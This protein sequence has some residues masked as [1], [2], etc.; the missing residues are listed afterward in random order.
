MVVSWITKKMARLFR[1]NQA[2]PILGEKIADLRTKIVASTKSNERRQQLAG[3][4]AE[5]FDQ[6]IRDIS[7]C[8]KPGE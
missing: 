8:G 4:I 3:Q 1:Q 7:G 2:G 5:F 6:L